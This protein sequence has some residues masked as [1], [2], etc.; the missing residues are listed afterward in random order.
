MRL[1]AIE[2]NAHHKTIIEPKKIIDEPLKIGDKVIYKNIKAGSSYLNNRVGKIVSIESTSIG[3]KFDRAI[4]SG[5]S[6]DGLCTHGHG[7]W[8]DKPN[9]ERYK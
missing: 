2:H 9:V 4:N 3:I 5:S 1:R 7:W 8:A 6:C